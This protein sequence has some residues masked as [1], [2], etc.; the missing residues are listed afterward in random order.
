L[1]RVDVRFTPES[2]HCCDPLATRGINLSVVPF[3]PAFEQGRVL[4]GLNY[5]F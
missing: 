3:P 4:V 1:S 5:K 2:G